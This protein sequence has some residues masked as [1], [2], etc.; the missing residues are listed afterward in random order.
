MDDHIRKRNTRISNKEV[1]LN[2]LYT[3]IQKWE[4]E[5]A[6]LNHKKLVVKKLE[7]ADVIIRRPRS[8]L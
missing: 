4:E 1:K 6:I 7:T 3:K 5:I 2:T 8:D